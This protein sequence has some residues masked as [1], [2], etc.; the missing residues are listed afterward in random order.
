MDKSYSLVILLPGLLWACASVHHPK[1]RIASAQQNVDA[2]AHV[3]SFSYSGNFFSP[4]EKNEVGWGMAELDFE[5]KVLIITYTAYMDSEC[6][7]ASL[8]VS[9]KEEAMIT[10]SPS[11]F[12][13]DSYLVKAKRSRVSAMFGTNSV[14]GA[15]MAKRYGLIDWSAGVYRDISESPQ[16][17]SNIGEVSTFIFRFEEDQICSGGKGESC[18]FRYK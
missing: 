10:Y 11:Q 4:C 14:Y 8:D 6:S 9:V 2:T 12:G 16:I 18:Y 5:D 3:S 1:A 15:N 7:E 17:K 13:Q